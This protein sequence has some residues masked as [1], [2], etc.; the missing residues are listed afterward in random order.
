MLASGVGARDS[1]ELR[2][3]SSSMFLQPR[4]TPEA[5]DGGHAWGTEEL[6]IFHSSIAAGSASEAMGMLCV[7]AA[8]RDSIGLR[9]PSSSVSWGSGA[10]PDAAAG[11]HAWA[12]EELSIFQAT[13][14]AGSVSEYPAYPASP[15]EMTGQNPAN[16]NARARATKGFKIR[17]ATGDQA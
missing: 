4:A 11:R 9:R 6:S 2:R 3:P 13:I 1:I 16:Q 15:R 10:T 14:A 5:D 17:S 12:T 7:G 8:A